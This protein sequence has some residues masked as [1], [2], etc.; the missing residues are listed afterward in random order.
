MATFSPQW[1]VGQDLIITITPQDV[2]GATG[3]W[4]DNALG[5]QTLTG[6]WDNLSDSVNYETTNLSPVGLGTANAVPFEQNASITLKEQV[7]A[8]P[9][10]TS[11]N[12]SLQYGNVLRNCL[13]AS[14]KWKVV[15]AL[16]DHTG[17]VIS[18]ESY[19]YYVLCTGLNRTGEKGQVQDEA[20][21]SL[22]T[23]IN[24]STG[25]VLANPTYS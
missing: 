6:R 19:T 15:I 20:T 16:Y 21:L 3:V 13:K 23:V 10:I 22:A 8:L 9:D 17:N 2:A 1:A 12:K 25:A 4:S 7:A 5:A 14:N 24:S 11:V 18:G